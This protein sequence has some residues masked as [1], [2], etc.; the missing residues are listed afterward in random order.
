[1]EQPLSRR[2]KSQAGDQAKDDEH[3][4]GPPVAN[5]QSRCQR[6]DSL[7]SRHDA[8]GAVYSQTLRS[9][10]RVAH[11]EGPDQGQTA[12]ERPF[13]GVGVDVVHQESD[14]HSRLPCSVQSRVKQRPELG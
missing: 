10:P 13:C 3:G 1:M 9:C 2:D 8:N 12:E 11:S 4:D 5:D 7:G 14:E 6:G